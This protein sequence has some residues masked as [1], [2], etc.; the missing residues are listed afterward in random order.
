M[1]LRIALAVLV[2]VVLAG[3]GSKKAS[4]APADAVVATSQGTFTIR[5]DAKDSPNTVASFEKLARKG[6]FDGTIFHRIVPGFV[7]QGGDPTGTGTG[8]P[9]YTTTDPPPANVRYTHGVV[10]MAK[11][12]AQAR[13]TA[14]SQFFV[15]TA[16]DAQLPPDYAI[17]GTVVQGLDVVDRIGKLGNP[18]T[19]KPT[20]RVVVRSITIR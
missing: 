13:G 14:G 4:T 18:V 11:T 20:K 16:Q 3:C 5:L 9:G 15:V 19:E 17:L 10:A 2:A 8:G 6:F 7:I 1:Q 12:P